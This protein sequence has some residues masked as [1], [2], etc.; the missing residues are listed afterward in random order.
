MTMS[1][2]TRLSFGAAA[3]IAALAA[4]VVVGPRF[5]AERRAAQQVELLATYC[6]DCHNAAERAGGV[7]FE[8]LTAD[9]FAAH[10]E[11]FE[12]AVAKL[13]GRLMP[14]PGNPQPDGN[15]V[16]TFVA[17]VENAID[18]A[19]DLPRAGHVPIQRMNR[20]ELARAFADLVAVEIDPV[21]YLPT[22]IEVDGFTNIA[23][24]L[25]TS[26]AFFEQYVSLARRVAHLAVGEPIPKLASAWFPPPEADQARYIDGLPMGTRGG[27]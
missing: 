7:S 10:P 25:S 14:P 23:A 12:A 27:M 17:F 19:A 15:A 24:A 6:T 18:T 21:E 4:A 8:Q 2:R 13:R 5:V 26:P 3:G 20:D 9:S 22:E 11:I 16:D 1:Q